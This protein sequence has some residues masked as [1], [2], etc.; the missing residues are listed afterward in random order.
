MSELNFEEAARERAMI[1]MI[2]CNYK[3]PPLRDLSEGRMVKHTTKLN[4]NRPD[5]DEF[6]LTILTTDG[7]KITIERP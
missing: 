4:A 5:L 2:L 6:S 7:F 1:K 3:V